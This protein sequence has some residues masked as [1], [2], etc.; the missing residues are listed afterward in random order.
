[1]QPHSTGNHRCSGASLATITSDICCTWRLLCVQG[2]KKVVLVTSIGT[3]DP[4]FPLNLLW[5]VL[6]WKKQGELAL[7][8]SGIDYTI[9]RPGAHVVCACLPA[10]VFSGPALHCTALHCS[11]VVLFACH[12]AA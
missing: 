9:V 3:D 8:R 4:L 11:A 6:L 12:T 1:M 7:Q 10:Y 5:G 2:V